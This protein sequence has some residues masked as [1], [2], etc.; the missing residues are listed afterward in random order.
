[1][2]NMNGTSMAAIFSE[3]AGVEAQPVEKKTGKNPMV[4]KIKESLQETISKDPT[5]ETRVKRLSNSLEVV[6]TLGFSER[7]SIIVDETK[8]N[9][10][11]RGLAQ[12]PAIV[13]YEVRNCG[14]EPIEYKTGV[15]TADAEGTYTSEEV[16]RVMNPGDV[17][18]LTRKYMTMLCARP[19][20]SFTL[21]NGKVIKGSGANNTKSVE[22]MLESFYFTFFKELGMK[23][24]SDEVKIRIDDTIDGHNVIK[25]E[26]VEAFGTLNNKKETKQRTRKAGKPEYDSSVQF[27]NYVYNVVMKDK[28]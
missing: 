2:E 19:E 1:M 12:T 6:H 11:K 22:A 24:N 16:V 9:A 27:A 25:P 17:V 26:Y 7:G 18:F 23:V 5:F 20:I 13:G 4:Q 21:K 14:S 15:C 28:D 10:N 8:T 3:N